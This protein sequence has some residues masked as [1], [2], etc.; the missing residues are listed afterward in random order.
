MTPPSQIGAP[1]LEGATAEGRSISLQDGRIAGS[2]VRGEGKDA[3]VEANGNPLGSSCNP[4][5]FYNL[6]ARLEFMA[7]SGVNMQVLSPPPFMCFTELPGTEAA[8]LLREQNESIATVV[9]HYPNSF[10]GLGVAP[11]QDT[12]RAPAVAGCPGSAKA[13]A[14][15]LPRSGRRAVR[16]DAAVPGPLMRTPPRPAERRRPSEP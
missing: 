13:V 1:A 10:R 7:Q 15:A 16:P 6:T 12:Q 5:D 4:E 8:P 3:V 14:C 2:R 9:Q 11:V